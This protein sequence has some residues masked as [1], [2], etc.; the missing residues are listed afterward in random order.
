M[1]RLRLEKKQE[2]R[3]PAGKLLAERHSVRGQAAHNPPHVTGLTATSSFL[4]RNE[5]VAK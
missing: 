3:F 2:F 4:L 1:H 5:G